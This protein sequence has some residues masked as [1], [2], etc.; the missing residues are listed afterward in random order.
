MGGVFL[1][2]QHHIGREPHLHLHLHANISICT[3]RGAG[4]YHRGA[5]YHRVRHASFLV[6]TYSYCQR[7]CFAVCLSKRKALTISRHGN[8]AGGVVWLSVVEKVLKCFYLSKNIN[9]MQCRNTVTSKSP[10]FKFYLS[11]S[12]KVLAS[13]CT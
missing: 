7:L 12:T 2:A 3:Y 8:T 1:K 5:G 10:V 4:K 11:K 9:T 6:A 13:N